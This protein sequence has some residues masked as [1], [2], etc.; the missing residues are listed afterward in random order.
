MLP[1]TRGEEPAPVDADESVSADTR[2]AQMAEGLYHRYRDIVLSMDRRDS[3][4]WDAMGT[5]AGDMN[6]MEG[7]GTPDE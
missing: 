7:R 4:I 6:W 3:F 2:H 1:M 5:D